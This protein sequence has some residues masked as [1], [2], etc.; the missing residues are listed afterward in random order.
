MADHVRKQLRDA[1]VARLVAAGLPAR[2]GRLWPLRP[3]DLPVV[4]VYVDGERLEP[5]HMGG[6]EAEIMRLASLR[7][8]VIAAGS[9]KVEDDLD[10]L[11]AR[12]ERAVFTPDRTPGPA[13]GLVLE[14]VRISMRAEGEAAFGHVVMEYEAKICT[15]MNAPDTAL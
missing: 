11:S 4:L 3:A 8:E 14:S 10:D 15:A 5:M 2:S 6:A 13:R 9:R 1:V 7:I 12:I